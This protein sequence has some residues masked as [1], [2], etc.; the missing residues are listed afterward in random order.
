L[1]L[2]E[3]YPV[4][5]TSRVR[6]GRPVPGFAVGE[7]VGEAEGVDEGEGVAVGDGYRP[8]GLMI[9]VPA[10]KADALEVRVLFTEPQALSALIA[11]TESRIPA[12][13]KVGMYWG[14][15]S[16]TASSASF[17][18]VENSVLGA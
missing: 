17:A 18:T 2:T 14:A 8:V 6:G 16:M 13:F 10:L 12:A 3:T 1:K 4:P 7:G 11:R 5:R 15:L 9:R